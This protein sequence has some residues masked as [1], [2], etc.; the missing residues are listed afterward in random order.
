MANQTV[1]T[2]LSVTEL[3]LLIS[4]SIEKALDNLELSN[5]NAQKEELITRK[6]AAKVLNVSLPTIDRLAREQHFPTYKIG[7]STRF[8]RKEVMR[9]FAHA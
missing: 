6:E 8:K 3:E 5:N 4:S 2:T 9:A 7:S 1:F